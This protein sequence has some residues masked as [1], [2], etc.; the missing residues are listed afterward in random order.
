MPQQQWAAHQPQV[1]GPTCRSTAR[2]LVGSRAQLNNVNVAS[3]KHELPH[4][5]GGEHLRQ[6]TAAN[7]CWHLYLQQLCIRTCSGPM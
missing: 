6:A 1:D 5:Q 2:H 4:D 3:T 7:G